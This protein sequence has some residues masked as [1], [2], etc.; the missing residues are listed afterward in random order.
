MNLQNSFDTS[1]FEQNDQQ[2]AI[3]VQNYPYNTN[4]DLTNKNIPYLMAKSAIKKSRLTD[5]I[6]KLNIWLDIP[7]NDANFYHHSQLI[8][9]VYSQLSF[10]QFIKHLYRDVAFGESNQD[11]I[12]SIGGLKANSALRAI[13][14]EFYA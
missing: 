12:H 3:D 11:G 7:N 10:N 13:Y 8:Q 2:L 4:Y 1:L 9:A 6:E 14:Y 5:S